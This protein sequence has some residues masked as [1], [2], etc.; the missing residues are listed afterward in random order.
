MTAEERGRKQC[1]LSPSVACC[2]ALCPIPGLIFRLNPISI[3]ATT[4]HFQVPAF[5]FKTELQGVVAK[6][7]SYDMEQNIQDLLGH[8]LSSVEF[9]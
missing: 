3:F 2:L 4:P 7:S 8:R 6:I 1:L 9:M 5:P